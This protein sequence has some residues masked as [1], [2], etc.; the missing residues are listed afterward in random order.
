MKTKIILLILLVG[1]WLP[2]RA[3]SQGYEFDKTLLG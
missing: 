2:F 1:F 3:K